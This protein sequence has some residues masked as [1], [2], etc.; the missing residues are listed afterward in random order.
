MGNHLEGLLQQL[1]FIEWL[2]IWLFLLAIP[3]YAIVDAVTAVRQKGLRKG[4]GQLS[5]GVIFVTL[6]VW[7]LI[8]SGRQMVELTIT[9]LGGWARGLLI[10]VLLCIIAFPISLVGSQFR[11]AFEFSRK[12]YWQSHARKPLFLGVMG[13]VI[14]TI[15]ALVIHQLGGILYASIYSGLTILALILG[16]FGQFLVPEI[17]PGNSHQPLEAPERKRGS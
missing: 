16:W 15:I 7:L 9:S 10:A 6:L 1:G 3:M 2:F 11:A 17:L 12:G 8:S 4:A 13:I 5:I 14:I